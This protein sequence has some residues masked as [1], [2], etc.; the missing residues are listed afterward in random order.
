MLNQVVETYRIFNNLAEES[1]TNAKI[2]TIKEHQNNPVFIKTLQFVYDDFIRT[3]VSYKT[4]F[5]YQDEPINTT[6][7]PLETDSL[8]DMMDYVAAHNTGTLLT[9]L[10]IE[11]FLDEYPDYMRDF[12]MNVFSNEL[13]VGI[14]AKTINKALGKGTI[15]EFGVQ[16]A[17]PYH[18]YIDKVQGQKFCLTQK[19]DGHRS[20]CFVHNGEAQFYTRKGLPINGLGSLN[21]EAINLAGRLGG[22]YVLDGELLL[23][24]T[25]GLETKDL[26]R[27]TSRILRSNDADK[28]G[29]L[30]NVFD[31]CPYD[32]F[33]LGRSREPFWARKGHLT[34]SYKQTHQDSDYKYRINLVKDL[35]RGNDINVIPTM[36][37]EYV[38][39][40]GWEG[41]MINLLDSP[42]MV[43]RTSSLLKVKEFFDADVMVKDVFEGEGNL[44][45]TLGGIV[46]DFKGY[47]IRVG[48]G[49][50]QMERDWYWENPDEIIGH[51]VDVQYFEET[52]NQNN[53][54]I[55]LRFPTFK[56][57][58]SDK[59][60]KGDISYE[61]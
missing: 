19:L 38:D 3:G 59:S 10:S 36:Q 1:S 35:Y 33:I 26:F 21:S 56:A 25:D 45:G 40:Y 50:T 5:K 51:I 16:L 23:K 48:S 41:L 57:V 9:V 7:T 39:Q 14:T 4:L 6:E 8:V 34:A 43:K 12:L 49:F 2:N 32:E 29:I 31:C 44:T 28:T 60:S 13:K 58:R 22:D 55:S 42:Y 24:N 15:R 18:K 53:D 52:H 20:V 61:S 27:A 54:D 37:K 17:Y 46:I 11:L 47:P 30:F